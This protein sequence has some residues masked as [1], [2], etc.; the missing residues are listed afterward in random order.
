MAASVLIFSCAALYGIASAEINVISPGGVTYSPFRDGQRPSGPCPS[1]EQIRDDLQILT[2]VG[3]RTVRNYAVLDCNQ[4]ALILRAAA[5]FKMDVILGVWLGK[6]ETA[7]SRELAR[8]K[9]LSQSH[10]NIR[11]VSVG[12]E[13]LLRRDLPAGKLLQYVRQAKKLT[14]VP[15]TTA[16]IWPILL[17]R[18]PRYTTEVDS[19]VNSLEFIFVN[20]HPFWDGVHITEAAR[21]VQT[22]LATLQARYPKKQTVISEIG[23]PTHGMTNGA[24]VPSLENQKTFI[25]NLARERLPVFYFSAFDEN[26]KLEEHGVGPHWGLHF[27]NR[28][29]KHP[30]HP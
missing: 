28:R 16:E 25:E 9:V 24:A 17:G 27:S 19:L 29:P 23:W 13:V 15:V 14:N 30:G 6:D 12:S 3:I 2:D 1:F 10:H 8:L 4:G 11:A 20:V 7:N 26:W 18:D 21:H 5:K 22:V